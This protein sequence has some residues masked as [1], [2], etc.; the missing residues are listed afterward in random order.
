MN[1]LELLLVRDDKMQQE[2]E[3][4]TDIVTKD[5]DHKPKKK[6]KEVYYDL[7]GSLITVP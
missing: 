4:I 2:T 1:F 5:K 7:E 6:I 3:K